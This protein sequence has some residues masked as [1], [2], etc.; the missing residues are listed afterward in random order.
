MLITFIGITGKNFIVILLLILEKFDAEHSAMQKYT[1][2]K[3]ALKML[4]I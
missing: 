4:D 1:F 2:G 3:T